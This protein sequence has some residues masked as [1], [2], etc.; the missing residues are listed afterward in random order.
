MCLLHFLAPTKKNENKT[1]QLEIHRVRA[2]SIKQAPLRGNRLMQHHFLY[3]LAYTVSQHKDYAMSVDVLFIDRHHAS[4]ISG[5][6]RTTQHI[7][8][9]QREVAVG[10]IHDRDLVA[11]GHNHE[12]RFIGCNRRDSRRVG[13]AVFI[14]TDV[15]R[16]HNGQATNVGSGDKVDIFA[17]GITGR[18]QH[19]CSRRSTPSRVRSCR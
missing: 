9:G 14:G 17:C 18:S 3:F 5:V 13:S 1:A 15:S 16:A 12:V 11:I 10:R 2:A 6:N 7:Y 8:H 4:A 19:C